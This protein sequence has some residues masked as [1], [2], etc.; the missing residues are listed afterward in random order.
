[1]AAAAAG[2]S[3]LQIVGAGLSALS[4][5]QQIQAGRQQ[6]AALRA[7]GVQERLKARSA[8]I[9]HRQEGVAVLENIVKTN[10]TVVARA[11]SGNT[12]P[13]TGTPMMLQ[14]YA[15]KEGFNE[16]GLAQ[17]NAD[18]A[19]A[20]GEINE[21]QY[22]MAATQARRQGV[23]NAVGTLASTA[24]T[25]GSIGGAPSNVTGFAGGGSAAGAMQNVIYPTASSIGM[26][27][28]VPGG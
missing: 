19:L 26:P 11:A 15:R 16:F 8:A 22:G 9:R 14:Q 28:M 1:M 6:A 17:D 20:V 7:Q 25:M 4:A 21:E 12:N 5:V 13:F 10:S 18:L 2:M 23:F 24:M 27:S 3:T